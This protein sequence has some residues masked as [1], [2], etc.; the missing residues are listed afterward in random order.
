MIKYEIR[1][2]KAYSCYTEIDD[3][4]ITKKLT[5]AK[6]EFEILSPGI[7]G[8]QATSKASFKLS[9]AAHCKVEE[10]FEEKPQ[11]LVLWLPLYEGE[12]DKLSDLSLY[13]KHGTIIG[14]IWKRTPEGIYVL[15][16]D[17]I[18]DYVST[19][20]ADFGQEFTILGWFNLQEDPGVHADYLG[21][22]CYVGGAQGYVGLVLQQA[23]S[24]YQVVWYS[25]EPK[26]KLYQFYGPAPAQGFR[27]L[28]VRFKAYDRCQIL[29]NGVVEGETTNITDIVHWSA[30]QVC[31]SPQYKYYIKAEMGIQRVY[32][33][34][35][36]DEDVA[37]I[38]EEEGT[39]YG[40]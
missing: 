14:A 2:P 23:Y 28:G 11:E 3:P 24:R 38:F 39:F 18:D 29:V 16:H 10:Q 22:F 27:L 7:F 15:S 1:F 13:G 8:K 32:S 33:K 31:A 5:G 34:W 4:A 37:R 20:L 25:S 26:P 19:P 17:G 40:V 21:S 12:G 6:T 9:P 35:L 36:S 30:F